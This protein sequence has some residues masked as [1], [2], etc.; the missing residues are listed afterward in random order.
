MIKQLVNS[1][2]VLEEYYFVVKMLQATTFSQSKVET[3]VTW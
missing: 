3:R 2:G 1:Q